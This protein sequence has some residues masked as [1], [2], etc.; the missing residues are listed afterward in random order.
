M[1]LVCLGYFYQIPA[2]GAIRSKVQVS[3]FLSAAVSFRLWTT[4]LYFYEVDSQ[5]SNCL[6][7]RKN[8]PKID[9]LLL[10]LCLL[11]RFKVATIFLAFRRLFKVFHQSSSNLASSVLALL[12]HPVLLVSLMTDL[13]DESPLSMCLIHFL[14]LSYCLS[15]LCLLQSFLSLLHLVHVLSSCLYYFIHRS[16]V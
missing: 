7:S 6:C 3:Y 4:E 16:P 8:L 15:G 1:F 14:S 10:V 13:S 11:G 12:L 5:L 9:L 2:M